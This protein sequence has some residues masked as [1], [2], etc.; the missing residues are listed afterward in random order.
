MVSE[1]YNIILYYVSSFLQYRLRKYLAGLGQFNLLVAI[2]RLLLKLQSFAIIWFPFSFFEAPYNRS[3]PH[4]ASKSAESL[5][6][7]RPFDSLSLD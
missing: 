5:V 4:L 6:P 7:Q 1:T 2:Q 3:L